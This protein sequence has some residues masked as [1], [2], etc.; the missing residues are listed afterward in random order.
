[1]KFKKPSMHG[2]EFMLCIKKRNRRM[3]G[4]T[5]ARTTQEQYAPPT[6]ISWGHNKLLNTI[7]N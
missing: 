5:H 2:S 6:S 4:C 7:K 3:E 1:M